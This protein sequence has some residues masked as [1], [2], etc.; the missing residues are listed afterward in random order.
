MP[1]RSPLACVRSW[2]SAARGR[3]VPPTFCVPAPIAT[4]FRALPAGPKIPAPSLAACV[5]RRRSCGHWASTLPSA[6]KAGPEAGSLGYEQLR[7][8]P[9][10]RHDLLSSAL[11]DSEVRASSE[12]PL[13]LAII[14]SDMA[15][16]LSAMDR[17]E[18]RGAVATQVRDQGVRCSAEKSGS[19]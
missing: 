18:R 11:A 9:S 15:P 5:V 12:G 19:E 13:R 3:A 14:L 2:P 17:Y 8:I 1:T 7:K 16:R 6:G 10:A 4:A